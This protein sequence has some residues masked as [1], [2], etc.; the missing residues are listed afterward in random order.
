VL[1][2]MFLVWGIGTWA[3][4]AAIRSQVK[5]RAGNV[6]WL[7]LVIAG[8]GEAMA[9]IF[10][11][12][13]EVGHGIAGLLGVVGFPPAA[14]LLSVCLGRIQLWR[15]SKKALL[16]L[17]NLNWIS[18]VLLIAT[19]VLMTVQM[20]KANGGHLPQHAPKLLPSGVLGLDGWADRLIILTNCLWVMVA[21][22]QTKNLSEKS[23]HRMR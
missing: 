21:A 4:A 14:L 18:V 2:L 8:L 5:T 9:S 13:H 19:L 22:W 16:W 23:D 12:T 3:L 10:D 7:F 6:G 17:A 1:S 11:V 15:G 20:T